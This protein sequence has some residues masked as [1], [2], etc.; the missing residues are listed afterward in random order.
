MLFQ[1]KRSSLGISENQGCASCS[2]WRIT[3]CKPHFL[4]VIVRPASLPLTVPQPQPASPRLH[5]CDWG[6]AYALLRSPALLAL[7]LCEGLGRAELWFGEGGREAEAKLNL[8]LGNF[9]ELNVK[10]LE[11]DRWLCPWHIA[12]K[13]WG[14]RNKIQCTRARFYADAFFSICLLLSALSLYKGWCTREFLVRIPCFTC[15]YILSFPQ[16]SSFP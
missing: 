5:A 14:F 9:S 16:T 3:S 1:C 11:K 13:W 8:Q 6:K 15:D 2:H 10:E 4:S 7:N 12:E